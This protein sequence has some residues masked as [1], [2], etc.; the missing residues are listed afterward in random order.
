MP[1]SRVAFKE[2]LHLALLQRSLAAGEEVGAGVAP[3]A[4][5]GAQELRGVPPERLLTAEAV[6]QAPDSDPVVLQ[7]DVLDRE[8][9]RL[10]HTEPV[11]VDEGEQGL[12]TRG[13]DHGEEAL[14][15]V[16]GE[17]LGEVPRGHVCQRSSHF[18]MVLSL[19]FSL[20][21]RNSCWMNGSHCG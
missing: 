4:Q 12:I 18:R 9:G 5:V 10:V 6:L 20:I 7:V 17:V 16:L 13:G 8:H 11:V 1:A 19:W 14:E 2:V 21:I 3:D 15:L